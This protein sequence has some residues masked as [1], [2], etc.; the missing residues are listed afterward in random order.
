M[1]L[2][3]GPTLK[4]K[5]TKDAVMQ[6]QTKAVN[7]TNNQKM[8]VNFCIPEFSAM[9]ILMWGFL[10]MDPLKSGKLLSTNSIMIDF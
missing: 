2:M 7:I 5:T 6:C 1:I 8:K 3:R 10:W 4:T 9:E